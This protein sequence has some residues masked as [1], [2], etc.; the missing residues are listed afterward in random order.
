[1]LVVADSSPLIV[2]I[3]IGHHGILPRLFEEIIAPPQVLAE[4]GAPSRPKPVREFAAA[5]PGWL[6]ERVPKSVEQIPTLHP[7]ELAAI[8]LAREMK[9]DLL[10][11]D[12]R[13]GR[14]AAAERR[15]AFT[16]T[17][18]VLELGAEAGLLNLE[19]AFD[20]VKRT[21]FWISPRLLDDRL[22]RF[23][24]RPRSSN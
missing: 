2:L 12:E 23:N 3:N 15:I 1:M 24:A 19:A 11:I 22:K 5:L 18:G 8:S 13:A 21:D 7:G 6:R 4:L 16:G 9:A 17:I 14:K 20:A 10:L